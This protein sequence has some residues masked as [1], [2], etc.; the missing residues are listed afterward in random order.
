MC[1]F[2]FSYNTGKF[3]RHLMSD[4]NLLLKDYIILYELS[5]MTPKCQCGY[6]DEDVPFFR[7]KFLERIG[8]HKK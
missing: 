1:G 5:G 6:C 8:D 2:D 4:H 3:T 7:G